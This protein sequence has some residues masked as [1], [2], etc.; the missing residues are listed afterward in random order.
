MTCVC[1]TTLLARGSIEP[2]SEDEFFGRSANR[3]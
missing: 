2:I 3:S 1:G